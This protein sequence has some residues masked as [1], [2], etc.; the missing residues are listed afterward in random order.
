M[1]GFFGLESRNDR[2]DSILCEQKINNGL[3]RRNPITTDHI[4]F[5]TSHRAIGDRHQPSARLDSACANVFR[6]ISMA[7]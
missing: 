2:M 1:N 4:P 7:E 5:V 3:N 6:T